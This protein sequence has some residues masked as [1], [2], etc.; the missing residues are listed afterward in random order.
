MKR[1][2]FN[3]TALYGHT[4]I[5]K[6]LSTGNQCLP[7]KLL[8]V[9]TRTSQVREGVYFLSGFISKCMTWKCFEN[10]TEVAYFIAPTL[11]EME[12]KIQ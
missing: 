1:E 3:R 11:T 8:F 10:K 7:L 9:I 2:L 12:G 5:R 6:V 4:A